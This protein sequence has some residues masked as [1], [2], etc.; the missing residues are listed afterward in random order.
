MTTFLKIPEKITEISNG[1]IKMKKVKPYLPIA[2][3]I[4]GSILIWIGGV[5]LLIHRIESV[6]ITIFGFVFVIGGI[7]FLLFMRVYFIVDKSG[8]IF[9]PHR[10]NLHPDNHTEIVELLHNNKINEVLKYRIDKNSPL[11]LELWFHQ[12][13]NNVYS[14]V[15]RYHDAGMRA[16]TQV[17]I[18]EFD[19][20]DLPFKNH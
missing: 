14:Q 10:Y 2:S 1:D 15:L 16:V 7:I 6:M 20:L 8:K 17:H 4:I 3:I 19:D 9:R 18:T 12:T 5:E 11:K 13:H